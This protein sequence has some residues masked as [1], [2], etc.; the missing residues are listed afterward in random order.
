MRTA[1][2]R[3]SPGT[4][5]RCSSRP[6]PVKR[7]V[8]HEITQAAIQHAIDEC[9]DVDYGLVDAQESRRIVDRLYGY[10]VS[11]V[12]WRKIRPGLSAGRV[13]SPERPPRRRAGARAHGVRRRQ[14]LGPRRR[15]PHRARV[16][17]VARHAS[18]ATGWPAAATSTARASRRRDDVAVLDEAQRAAAQ[19]RPRRPAV[20]GDRSV[21]TKPYT[22]RPKPPFITSTLQQVGGSRLRMSSR[23]VMSLA[24]GLYEDGYI[25]YMRTDSTTLSD[26]RASRGRPPGDRAPVRPRVPHRRAPRLRQ[27]VEERAGGP[28]GHPPRRRQLAQP[29]PAPRP[30]CAATSSAS[31]S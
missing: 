17:R 19:G 16:H 14:L 31:T 15:V 4:C 11:E 23:Q 5:S 2:A 13:Q 28:R 1:R 21:E 6:C 12:C 22:S 25:T 30:S 24:Q 29:R 7:M 9:R 10:P 20:R 8:F 26:D 3:P 27:E 18:T